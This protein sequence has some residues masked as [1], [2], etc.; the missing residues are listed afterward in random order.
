MTSGEVLL[1]MVLTN[2]EEIVK[3]IQIGSSLSCS[4]HAL[5]EFIILKECGLGKEWSQD[6]ELEES[7][8]QVV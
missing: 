2:V 3:D 5:V 4:N 7:E 6:P 1:D 8:L